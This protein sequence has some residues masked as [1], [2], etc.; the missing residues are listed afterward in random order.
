MTAHVTTPS[1]A[2]RSLA[3]TGSTLRSIFD[4]LARNSRGA[5]SAREAERLFAM[6]DEELG[7]LG[8]DR[9]N[10][11]YHAFGPHIFI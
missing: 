1:L 2:Q 11:I 9:R 3:A 5:R 4:A 8:I 10:I 6:S 7:R